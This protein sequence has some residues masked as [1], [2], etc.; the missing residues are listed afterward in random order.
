MGATD[1]IW[2]GAFAHEL[3]V[4]PPP[5][6]RPRIGNTNLPDL[7]FMWHRGALTDLTQVT[8]ELNCICGRAENAMRRLEK[9]SNEARK[10]D[11]ERQNRPWWKRLSGAQ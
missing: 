8:N 7:P 6:P 2:G 9:L 11:L 4:R 1:A 10:A 3:I 5:Y